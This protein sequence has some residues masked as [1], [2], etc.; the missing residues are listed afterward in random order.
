M[1]FCALSFG[2]LAAA[3]GLVSPARAQDERRS[4]RNLLPVYQLYNPDTGDHLYTVDGHEADVVQEMGYED[5]G[6]PFYT[7]A[8][9]G[10]GL[11]PLYRFIQGDDNHIYSTSRRA[12]YQP[13]THLEKI[14]GYISAR[15]RE[16]LRPLYDYYNRRAGRHF[17]TTSRRNPRGYERLGVLGY[18]VTK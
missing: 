14:I 7:G 12:G 15:P 17:Y 18:V 13:D 3:L 1:R 4:D 11:V 2:V 9:R 10:P 8:E 6:V 5:E 16:G